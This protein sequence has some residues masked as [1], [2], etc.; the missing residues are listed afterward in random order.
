MHFDGDVAVAGQPTQL[1]LPVNSGSVYVF[2]RSDGVWSEEVRLRASDPQA[3][4]MFGSEV[5]VSGQVILSGA[6]LYDSTQGINAGATYVIEHD[7]G[8]WSQ[9]TRLDPDRVRGNQTFGISIALEGDLAIV[10]GPESTTGALGPGFAIVYDLNTQSTA[11]VP[12]VGFWGYG[13]LLLTMVL[14]SGIA[15]ARRSTAE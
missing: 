15:I 9:L 13:I 5:A 7:Q 3:G 12:G 4:A 10:G 14:I 6:P 2:R 1:A 11:A 8:V